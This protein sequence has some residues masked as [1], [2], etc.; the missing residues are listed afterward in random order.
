M[1]F[2]MHSLNHEAHVI[3]EEACR[4]GGHGIPNTR[5]QEEVTGDDNIKTSMGTVKEAEL[6]VED[7]EEIIASASV[8]DS[9][10]EHLLSSSYTEIK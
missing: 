7:I 5:K 6:E 1:K 3:I 10:P 4:K 9:K 2:V 8:C